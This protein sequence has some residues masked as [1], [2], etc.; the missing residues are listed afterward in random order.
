MVDFFYIALS[1]LPDLKHLVHTEIFFGEPFTMALTCLM[2][3]AHAL[4]ACLFEWLTA[5]PV[6]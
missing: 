5:F 2:L 1:T 4:L 3:G 6:I